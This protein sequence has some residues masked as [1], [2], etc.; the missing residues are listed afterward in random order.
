VQIAAA[1]TILT[2]LWLSIPISTTQ[3]VIGAIIGVGFARG[4]I[5]PGTVK[6]IAFSWV[7]GLPAAIGIAA[8]IAYII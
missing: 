4:R 1:I 6:N 2:F 8:L 7:F 5:E 3:T